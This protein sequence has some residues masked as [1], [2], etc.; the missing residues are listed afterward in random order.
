MRPLD[1]AGLIENMSP[2]DTHAQL[3]PRAGAV[4]EPIMR[5]IQ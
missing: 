5:L 2:C 1:V 3:Q 4:V